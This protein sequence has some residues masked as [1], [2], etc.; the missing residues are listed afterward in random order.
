MRRYAQVSSV[1][2]AII[3]V[4]HLVRLVLKVPVQVA[5]LSIPIWSSIG[6]FVLTAGLAVWGFRVAGRNPSSG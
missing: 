2:F 3:A 4:A 5:D 6:G 1:F